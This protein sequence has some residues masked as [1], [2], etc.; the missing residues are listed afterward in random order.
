MDQERSTL[1][2]VLHPI[3]PGSIIDTIK[4]LGENKPIW[5]SPSMCC[6]SITILTHLFPLFPK[7]ATM[8][9]LCSL[10]TLHIAN[11]GVKSMQK[12]C[13]MATC[14]AY[15]TINRLNRHLSPFLSPN[16]YIYT[17]K[18][19]VCGHPYK[20]A[21][22]RNDGGRSE[23]CW[24]AFAFERQGGG[25]GAGVTYTHDNNPWYR[26]ISYIKPTWNGSNYNLRVFAWNDLMKASWMGEIHRL[27]QYFW[28]HQSIYN[29]W[30]C[31]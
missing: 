22:V 11:L 18:T 16:I 23:Q 19:K 4:T 17:E 1:D 29:C 8:Q 12:A 7:Q 5:S 25:P 6:E 28:T 30:Q 31:K 3:G 9:I 21:V 15:N 20:F 2:C 26:C 27:C 10:V 24:G 13:F 14:S